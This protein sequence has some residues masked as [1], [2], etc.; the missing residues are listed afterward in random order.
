MDWSGRGGE[1]LPLDLPLWVAFDAPLRRPVRPSAVRVVAADGRELGPFRLEVRG[2]MLLLH[3]EFPTDPDL[4]DGSLPPATEAA[5]LLAGVPQ[6]QAV[7]GADGRL[8]VGTRRLPFVTASADRPEA[9]SGSPPG[10]G[11]LW[12]VGLDEDRVL[13]LPGN[14][15]AP[16]R[17]RFD[18]PLDP[19][20]LVR[21]A[22]LVAA[23]GAEVEVPMRVVANA[24]EGAVVE[25]GLGDWSGR[26]VLEFPAGI[27][28]AG[29]R[30]LAASLQRVRVWRPR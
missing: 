16:P 21:R 29:G 2:R 17:I 11:P 27:Q 24:P 4:A 9:L 25:L 28:G 8:L 13:W 30:P 14:G 5:I 19:R 12:L 10:A 6:F 18:G 7:A 23:D 20:T 3:P 26:G 1:A 15:E 22:R